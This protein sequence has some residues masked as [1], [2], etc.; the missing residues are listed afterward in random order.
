MFFST[1]LNPYLSAA[2]TL[3]MFCAPAILHAHRSAW[4]IWLPGSPLLADFLRF[5]FSPEWTPGW[6]PVIIAF[7]QSAL[8]W[9]LAAVIFDRRDIATPVE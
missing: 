8:F 1:F 2:M 6:L 5:S 9:A 4:S 7:L 3:V